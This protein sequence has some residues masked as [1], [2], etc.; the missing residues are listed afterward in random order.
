M[1][2]AGGRQQT[3]SSASQIIWALSHEKVAERMSSDKLKLLERPQATMRAVG[4]ELP[5]DELQRDPKDLT[6]ASAN[7]HLARTSSRY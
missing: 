5:V 2:G 1:L 4:I 7:G 6:Y 3:H